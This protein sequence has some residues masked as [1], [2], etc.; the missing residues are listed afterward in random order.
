VQAGLLLAMATA[1][2]D[3]AGVVD[4]GLPDFAFWLALGLTILT[5]IANTFTPSRPERLVWSPVTLAMTATATGVA[6][7]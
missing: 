7:L 6:L 3:R 1:V 4:A 2:L 5:A